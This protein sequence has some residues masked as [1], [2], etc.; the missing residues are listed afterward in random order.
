MPSVIESWN[1]AQDNKHSM[2]AM[3]QELSAGNNRNNRNNRSNSN[4]LNSPAHVSSTKATMMRYL[5]SEPPPSPGIQ[6]HYQH[7]P[8][9]APGEPNANFAPD[10]RGCLSCGDANQVFGSFPMKVAPP[11]TIERLQ[12]RNYNIKFNRPQPDLSQ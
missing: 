12:H 2:H 7:P 3:F 11:A 6:T 8:L 4:Y 5:P 9:S 10:F 1:T